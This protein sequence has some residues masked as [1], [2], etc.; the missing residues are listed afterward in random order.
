ML[1]HK[2]GLTLPHCSHVVVMW[3]SVTSQRLGDCPSGPGH[4][5]AYSQ[6][7]TTLLCSRVVCGGG[8]SIIT[9]E[10]GGCIWPMKVKTL[11]QTQ[12]KK[13]AH[14]WFRWMLENSLVYLG[15]VYSLLSLHF[16]SLVKNLRAEHVLCPSPRNRKAGLCPP[17]GRH[18][19]SAWHPHPDTQLI[20][21]HQLLWKPNV[22]RGINLSTV[23]QT[24]FSGLFIF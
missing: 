5:A 13:L 10:L 19:Q 8:F 18:Q 23:W 16:L 20:P 22:T 2:K 17:W 6:G 24:P 3:R 11:Y 14:S 1:S 12:R 7:T 4:P 15:C 21:T 9:A